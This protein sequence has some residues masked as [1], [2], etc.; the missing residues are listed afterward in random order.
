VADKYVK[1]KFA[2]PGEKDPVT[3]MKMMQRGELQPAKPKEEKQ[4]VKEQTPED[5]D[6]ASRESNPDDNLWDFEDV[7]PVSKP[8]GTT[9][10]KAK[11]SKKDEV[12]LMEFSEPSH[13]QPK[14]AHSLEHSVPPPHNQP[15]FHAYPPHFPYVAHHSTPP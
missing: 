6:K 15:A 10:P 4:K 7:S 2:V 13:S 1:K 8:S 12:D 5:I 9:E 11:I 3:L 14:R